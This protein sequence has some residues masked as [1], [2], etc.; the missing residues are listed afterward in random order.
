MPDLDYYA[1]DVVAGE[2]VTLTVS[3]AESPL[4][5][6]AMNDEGDRTTRLPPAESVV[7]AGR[8]RLGSI[9][10]A[11]FVT[12]LPIV[13]RLVMEPLAGIGEVAVPAEWGGGVLV[14]VVGAE[15]VQV[16]RGEFQ[17]AAELRLSMDTYGITPKGQQDRRWARP[18]DPEVPSS[19]PQQQPA[20]AGLYA[21]LK[22]VND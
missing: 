8:I 1:F 11:V 19:Q 17:R 6:I 18:D 5:F 16:E 3:P 7:A 15:P 2:P 12:M 21:H 22:V 13:I 10:G 20:G 4:T 9:L 14:G